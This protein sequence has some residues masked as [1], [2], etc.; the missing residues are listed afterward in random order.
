[1]SDR[2]GP[3][4]KHIQRTRRALHGNSTLESHGVPISRG[5]P[6]KCIKMRPKWMGTRAIEARESSGALPSTLQLPYRT[7]CYS[8]VIMIGFRL[9]PSST[10]ALSLVLP[11]TLRSTSFAKG[12][13]GIERASLSIA[14]RFSLSDRFG[15]SVPLTELRAGEMSVPLSIGDR[16]RC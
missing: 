3:K 8:S 15:P 16:A 2:W 13:S 9:R 4:A 10:L 6:T 11:A 12:P 5:E 7:N 14:P 1:M